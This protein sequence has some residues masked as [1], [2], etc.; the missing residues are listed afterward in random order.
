MSDTGVHSNRGLSGKKSQLFVRKF[1]GGGSLRAWT[2]RAEG[3][4]ELRRALLDAS[5]RPE[6]ACVIGLA[7]DTGDG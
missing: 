5:W 2:G 3:N 4:M 1:L 7:L 6:Q